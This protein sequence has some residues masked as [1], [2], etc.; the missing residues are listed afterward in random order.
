MFVHVQNWTNNF[1]EMVVESGDMK[2][3]ASIVM[4]ILHIALCKFV[5]NNLIYLQRRL[6]CFSNQL[7]TFTCLYKCTCCVL[8]IS[9]VI[10][11]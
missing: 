3:A 10:Q 5:C 2:Y 1:T 8:S 4:N 9:N 7:C 11:M 6:T